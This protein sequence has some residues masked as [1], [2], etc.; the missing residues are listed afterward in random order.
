MRFNS[1]VALSEIARISN[2]RIIGPS[3]VSAYGINEIHMVE[4]GD[5]TFVDHPKYYD[6][7]LQSA[8]TYIIINKEVEV[9]DG[10]SLLFSED[11]F[12]AYVSIVRHFRP[13]APMDAA[14][15]ST[16]TIGQGTVLQPGV[17]V[18]NHAI[19]GRDCILHPGVVIYD[20]CIIG[21][22]VTIHAGTVIGADAF[23]FKRR[24]EGYDKMVSC[25]RVIIEDD[26]EIGASCTIDK[27]VSGDT[28]IGKGTKFDNMVHIGHDT[29]IGRNCLFAAQVG[30]AGVVRVE[31][32]V[33]L[34]GQ[35]GV[36]KDLVI[37]K[38]AVVLG[39]SGVPKSLKGGVTYFGS[40]VREAREKM[41]ELALIKRL[42]E[43]IEHLGDS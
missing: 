25:G 24:P 18:G 2:S 36:Q 17:H 16:A 8:A 43:I 30:V 41:K 11:P 19:I 22:R 23:Y 38:G 20:H 31:D 42:P 40:P 7:A 10:K 4:S 1:P 34:W 6:K 13:I 27:G 33:I 28:V 39:Q 26:V 12:S 21:D 35:V 15:S 14:I 9:P 3:D 29:V 32:D 5:I 37:G